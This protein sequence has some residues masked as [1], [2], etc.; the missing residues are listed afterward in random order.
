MI[1]G[2]RFSGALVLVLAGACTP[3][4]GA[5][6]GEGSSSAGPDDGSTTG[7]TSGATGQMSLGSSSGSSGPDGSTS[8]DSGSTFVTFI[9]PTG[10]CIGEGPDG[11]SWHCT[12]ECSVVL[13]ECPA[14]EKCMPWAN[15]GSTE[16]NASRCSPVDPMPV[17]VGGACTV[18][19]SAV[20]GLDDCASGSMCWAVDPD[21]LMGTCEAFCDPEAPDSCGGDEQCVA[22]NEGEVPVCL[23]AC[24]PLDPDACPEGESCRLIESEQA[25]CVPDQGGTLTGSSGTCGDTTCEA[26]A[27]CVDPTR[28]PGCPE[29]CCASWCDLDDPGA[30]AACAALDPALACVPWYGPGDAP[31]GLESLGACL[32]PV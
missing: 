23:S 21:S 19:G 7:T 16:W 20:S 12:F 6:E 2:L 17:P 5:D 28:V 26:D 25:Y 4:P 14:G 3:L 15:D 9:E 10:G 13:D 32:T 18:V 22:L 1:I 27:A 30:D 24:R 8:A 29:D 11:S 31:A